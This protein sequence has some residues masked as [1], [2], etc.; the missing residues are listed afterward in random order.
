MKTP[1][2][3][4]AKK[5]IYKGESYH[6]T[7]EMKYAQTLDLL[8]KAGQVKKWER[9]IKFKIT[10][11]DEF[12]TSYILDFKVEYTDGK[13]E[14]VDVKGMKSGVPYDLFK[15]KKRLMKAVLGIEIIEI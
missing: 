13:I 4:K 5:A 3:Y 14:Y 2:K 11:N 1:N 12:I 15:V 6:S 9:Q 7:K 10:V 8:I